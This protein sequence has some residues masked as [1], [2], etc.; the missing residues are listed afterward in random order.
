MGIEL[1][2]VSCLRNVGANNEVVVE[3]MELFAMLGGRDVSE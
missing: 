2:H 1:L 3:K